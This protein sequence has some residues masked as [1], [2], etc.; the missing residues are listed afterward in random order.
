M[1]N[2]NGDVMKFLNLFCQGYAYAFVIME[3]CILL[4]LIIK[5]NKMDNKR[6]KLLESNY[7][8]F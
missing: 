3:F 6:R 7:R 5:F 2:K 1:K 8:M 4:N